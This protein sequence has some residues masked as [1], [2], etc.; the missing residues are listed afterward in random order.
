MQS[1]TVVCVAGALVLSLSGAAAAQP[2]SQTVSST[3]PWSIG[4]TGGLSTGM[5]QT[6]GAAGAG[7]TFDILD[8]IALDSRGIWLSPGQGASG[9]EISGT[10]LFTLVRGKNVSPY[11]GIGGGLYRARLALGSQRM[12]GSSGLPFAPGAVVGASQTYC[13]GGGMMGGGSCGTTWTDSS[14]GAGFNME[15][16]PSFYARR[17]GRLVVPLDGQWSSRSFT[18][19]AMTLGFGAQVDLTERLY[20]RPEARALVVFGGGD[21]LTL[22]TVTVGFGIRF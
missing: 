18:D 2:A 6:G 4:A 9:L 7:L 20:V 14:T 12:F 16:M 15:A 11:I 17:L 5:M 1:Q 22:G 8:R 13:G 10:L 3:R 19:P 21:T